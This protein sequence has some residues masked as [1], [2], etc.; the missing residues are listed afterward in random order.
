MSIKEATRSLRTWAE[1]DL[2]A[3][4]GNFSAAR[5]RL[6]SDIKLLAVIKAD[7]YG[8]GA[9]EIAREL[10]A[11]ADFFAVA[12]AD[13]AAELRESGIKTP[14]LILGYV[15]HG[16]YRPAIEYDIRLTLF[17]YEDATALSALAEG[18]H[19]TV[20]VHF[21]VDTGMGRIGV[22]ADEHGIE[23]IKRMA[24]LP[25]IECE[26]LFS[27]FASAD[28]LDPEYTELQL[29]RFDD[30]STKLKAEL[31]VPI[32]H[33]YNS[34]AILHLSPRYDMARAGII[35]YGL[36][37]SDEVYAE[38]GELR[39][40]MT[41][42]TRVAYVKTL[43][44]GESVSYGHT[45]TAQSERR[46]A[47]LCAGY[48]DG[49]PR[50]LSD[51]GSV[52]V[53][54]KEAPILGRICMDQLMVDVTDLPEC[55]AGDEAVLFGYDGDGFISADTVGRLSGTIGYDVICGISKRVP[56]VYIR[57]GEVT[58]I[59]YSIPHLSE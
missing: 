16:D 20:K 36:R 31:D 21:A 27:H 55:K 6:P 14:I 18:M 52:L 33:M 50:Q 10:D 51:G 7:A 12:A 24:A 13:E 15:P 42:K 9:P 2:D 53:C 19:R 59:N 23:E 57:G 56:R 49:I 44:P 34:A 48:A 40:A 46:V 45:Y 38:G 41:L 35:L 1:I 5:R 11:H 58:K 37:P 8:H 54:G 28:E 17:S 32:L 39:Q 30:F 22:P 25:G 4:N 43:R 29:R 47:T 26:G 3:I